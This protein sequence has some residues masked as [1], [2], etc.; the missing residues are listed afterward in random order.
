[1]LIL[2]LVSLG[3]SENNP[4]FAPPIPT[5]YL[6]VSPPVISPYRPGPIKTV[7]SLQSVDTIVTI[8]FF[9]SAGDNPQVVAWGLGPIAY[10]RVLDY[11]TDGWESKYVS[12]PC[13]DRKLEAEF[14]PDCFI[15]GQRFLSGTFTFKKSNMIC[16][17]VVA[18]WSN[19]P[20]KYSTVM[21]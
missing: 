10:K 9:A 15:Q 11:G 19:A 16:A 4:V 20:T 7:F 2:L 18:S 8:K 3:C 13:P 21:L 17:V 1:M 14:G 5:Y 6:E 12:C